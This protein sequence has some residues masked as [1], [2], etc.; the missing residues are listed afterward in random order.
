MV[1]RKAR[2]GA[3]AGSSFWGCSKYPSC[4]GIRSIS[5]NRASTTSS[6]TRK[7]NSEAKVVKLSDSA[8]A[9]TAN[10]R[11]VDE[12]LIAL[13]GARVAEWKE[14]LMDLSRRNNLL[15]FRETK[16]Q[17]LDLAKG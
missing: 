4:S 9:T 5:R 8:T 6:L 1:R 13:I 16:T 11:R 7:R 15:F 2:R 17:H 10:P 14:Q 12:S 3:H